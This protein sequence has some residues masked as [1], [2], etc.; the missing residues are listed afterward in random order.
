MFFTRTLSFPYARSHVN[1]GK[2]GGWK[3]GD[4]MEVGYINVFCAGRT[5]ASV[6]HTFAVFLPK[7]IAV[8]SHDCVLL[9][10]NRHHIVWWSLPP[11][12]VSSTS[13]KALQEGT[14]Q[15][16]LLLLKHQ[17]GFRHTGWPLPSSKTAVDADDGFF[18]SSFLF[19]IPQ[20]NMELQSSMGETTAPVKTSKSVE[21]LIYGCVLFFKINM[22]R[23]HE[24][25]SCLCLLLIKRID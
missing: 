15:R 25:S 13:T 4:G 21:I 8:H 5:L 1:D 17:N 11:R 6:S 3:M 18:S 20:P 16:R 10:Q 19:E 24:D 22:S 12:S 9:F 23:S 2:N 14:R 7:P